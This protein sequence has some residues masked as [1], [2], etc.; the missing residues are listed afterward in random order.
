MICQSCL[1]LFEVFNVFSL[2]RVVLY[3]VFKD[4]PLPKTLVK[5]LAKNLV[6]NLGG[7]FCPLEGFQKAFE[8]M[9]LKNVVWNLDA[10]GIV[11]WPQK[12]FRGHET[13][14]VA[15]IQ[16]L[17]LQ[18]ISCSRKTCFVATTHTCH[19]ATRP[20]LCPQNM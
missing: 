2:G 14:L 5:T 6:K 16:F 20:S 7:L 4:F 13:R 10:I 18:N 3:T 15:S 19:V 1:T 17:W 11:S 12:I 8:N 9:C